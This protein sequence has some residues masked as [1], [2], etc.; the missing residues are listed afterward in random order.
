MA[1]TMN[2]KSGSV[3]SG[4]ISVSSITVTT[5]PTKTTYKSGESFDA[6]GMVVTVM[7]SNG[8][9]QIATGYS[10]SPT[11]LTDGVTAV[12]IRYTEAGRSV[13][14]TQ[15]VTVT[16]VLDSITV[17]P[18]TTTSYEY[19]D[20]LDTT[21]MVVTAHYTDGTSATVSGATA[22]PT[23]LNTVGTQVITVSYTEDSI[24]VTTTFGVTVA[25][26]PI[27]V[28]SQSGTLTYNGTAQEPTFANYD[29]A[30]MTK[31]VVAQTNAGTYSAT[32]VIGDNY[33]WSDTGTTVDRI[34][35]WT[36]G[37][38]TPTVT[39]PTALT[40]TYNGTPQT[41]VSA[42]STTGGTLEY[43]LDDVSYEQ[44]LPSAT[45]AGSYMVYYRVAG[46]T[47]Y[48]DVT[49]SSISVSI[50]KVTPTVTAP[51]KASDMTYNG[52]SRSL[53]ATLGSTN[54][55]TLQ[56]STDNLT[57]STSAPTATNAGSYTVYYKVVGDS[58]VN[59]V[60]STSLGSVSIA[61]ATPATPT[62][63][64]SSITLNNTTTSTTF[65]VTRSGDGAVTATSSN[66]SVATVSVSGTTVT[67]TGVAY[68]S[69]TVT[70]KVNAGTNYNA[71]TG[72]GC[73]VSVTS[74]ILPA[75]KTLEQQTWAEISQVSAANQ[76]ANYWSV[77]DTKSIALS[78]TC[79]TLALNTTLYCYILGFNHNS[80]KEGNGI[81]F[82][83]WKTAAS[84]GVDVCL[85]DANYGSNKSDGTKTFNMNHWGG[86]SSPYNTNYGGWKGC[87]AR[88]D[89][90][91][92][93]KTAPSGYGSTPAT[94]RVG[95]DAPS[96]TATNPV[97]NTLMSCLPSALR[98]VMKPMTKYTDN[99]GNSS[100]TDA[101]ISSSVDYLPLLAEWEI[102][103]ARS[104]A[105]EYEKN[106]QAQYTYYSS[107]NSKVKYKHN[108]TTTT[109]IWW[110]RSPIYSNAGNFCVVATNG[111]ANASASRYSAGLAPAFKV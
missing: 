13:T 64:K 21:G 26:K 102:F 49:A 58:N 66:T 39:A 55:G 101:G 68:G 2:L 56:Y 37:K 53:L 98:S 71:Y 62:A 60:A 25:R 65:T 67:V 97:S 1:K 75:K 33:V 92:S 18:P 73:T 108:A 50:A 54:Y 89:I 105:N 109:A 48:Y 80:S 110:E 61:K 85:V 3:T 94:S 28:P 30:K 77:G 78:G 10:V 51:T 41:L 82:G 4:G 72:T 34:V 22:S 27:P 35:P 106:Y 74:S 63:S 111:N 9:S 7:Y 36:I 42:G 96:D 44:A 81:H 70:V 38:A 12:T 57:W 46:G 17:T 24:T 99:K 11:E 45:N 95:Y 84:N 14:T 16:P 5:P 23:T 43:S 104:Y 59:D 69:T 6:T 90:L 88:Y 20:N 103:G 29:A 93:T 107:G 76:G 19:G 83:T 52:N 79:G 87:D 32:F 8:L 86:S 40:L 100:N 31:S 91:G 47:N 15:A